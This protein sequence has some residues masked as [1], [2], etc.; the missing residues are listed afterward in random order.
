MMVSIE[1][2]SFGYNKR[3][4][5]NSIN[6][7]VES[8]E[9]VG[10]IGENGAGKSTLIE[11]LLSINKGYSGTVK[12]EG[13]IGY[14]PQA[15]DTQKNFPASVYEV[16]YSGSII[17][18][19]TGYK[20]RINNAL[21]AVNISNLANKNFNELSGGQQQRVLIARALSSGCKLLVLDEP[22]KGLDYKTT[23]SLY[24]LLNDLNKN[25]GYTII[26]ITHDIEKIY[27][28]G[29]VLK[30]KNGGLEEYND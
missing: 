16:V 17:W 8:G 13:Q 20:D 10:I 23:E 4:V 6:L 3:K 9:F 30:L 27:A 19:K 22:T 5:I 1:N 15:S 29:R 14:L 7:T 24:A 12:V 25:A 28:M 11:C 2:L 18:K 26:M 21:E